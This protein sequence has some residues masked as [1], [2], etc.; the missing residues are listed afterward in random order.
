[1]K[2]NENRIYRCIVFVFTLSLFAGNVSAQSKYIKLVWA[3]EFNY[4][5][6]PNGSKWNFAKGGHGCGNNELQ[7]Y[8]IRDT[9]NAMVGN[10]VLKIIARKQKMA[11][12]F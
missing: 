4:S 9:Q 5:G 11:C 7:Y 3:N 2:Y 10:R 1:M 6:F 8:T 12:H